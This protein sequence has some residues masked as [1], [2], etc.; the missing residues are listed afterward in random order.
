MHINGLNALGWLQQREGALPP[1]SPNS[2][3]FSLPQAET[4]ASGPESPMGGAATAPSPNASPIAAAVLA[5]L[6]A[7]RDGTSGATFPGK[8]ATEGAF[9]GD[10]TTDLSASSGAGGVF[11]GAGNAAGAFPGAG[12]TAGVFP[13]GTGVRDH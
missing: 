13:G 7:T 8:G 11:P 10:S 9:P 4:A 3:K 6:A 12:A 2:A 1:Q 5:A